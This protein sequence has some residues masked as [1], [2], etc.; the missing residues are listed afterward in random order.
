MEAALRRF[1]AAGGKM[2]WI[3]TFYA[4]PGKGAADELKRILTMDPKPVGIQ[5]WGQVG[6]DL[7]AEQKLDSVVENLKLLRDAGVLVGLG[8]HDPRV[9]ERAE[10]KGWDLDFYQCCFYHHK[11]A[12]PWPEE[13]R[14]RMTAVIRK[15]SKPCIGFKVLAG[16]RHTKTP[17]DV[18][19]ALDYAFRRMKPTDVVLVGMWQKHKDQVAENAAFVRSI[20]G[21]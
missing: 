1:Y 12:G 8:A 16:N 18:R 11:P 6:D 2:Q 4:R 9:I 7:C 19:A 5:Q 13:D 15:A 14:E 10:E 21:G 20:L 3:S 17:A